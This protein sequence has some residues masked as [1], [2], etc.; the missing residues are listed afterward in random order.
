MRNTEIRTFGF[1][2]VHCIQT[3]HKCMV[4][5]RS[6]FKQLFEN[7]TFFP[8]FRQFGPPFPRFVSQNQL[9]FEACSSLNWLKYFLLYYKQLQ[10]GTKFWTSN[11]QIV[12]WYFMYFTSNLLLSRFW[13]FTV[14]MIKVLFPVEIS[15]V[16]F[17]TKSFETF[18]TFWE[19]NKKCNF[20]LDNCKASQTGL[21]KFSK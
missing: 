9:K 3:H 16:S 2:K 19:L 5:K 4:F 13:I 18:I 1:W 15:V 6:V 12:S 14:L 8:D 10:L 7:W 21:V 11:C 17:K 20:A